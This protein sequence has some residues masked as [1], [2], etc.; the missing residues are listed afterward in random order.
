M[1]KGSKGFQKGK[2]NPQFGKKPHNF[3]K[4]ASKKTKARLSKSHIGYIM[5]EDIKNKISIANKNK[6]KPPRT[7][8]HRRKIGDSR[9]GVKSHFW[10]DGRS[11][12]HNK[13]PQD[14]I[15]DL[16]NRIRKRDDYICIIC[17]VHQD[18]LNFGQV[19]K[20]DIHH[21]DYDMNNLLQN[22]LISLCRS[23][24]MKTNYN[25]KYW[26]KYFRK[27]IGR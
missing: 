14:W 6:M 10:I 3:G 11:K 24:H 27:I 22:N 20:L 7:E 25:R 16:R 18:E 9:R 19:K 8:A 12:E 23:C 2:D 17:G 4:K 15:D 13:Y 1:P 21:I 5:P 26:I